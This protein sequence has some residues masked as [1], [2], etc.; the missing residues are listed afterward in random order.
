MS[1]LSR[2][3]RSSTAYRRTARR[4][5]LSLPPTTDATSRPL[6]PELKDKGLGTM[7][8]HFEAS[9]PTGRRPRPRNPACPLLESREPLRGISILSLSFYSNPSNFSAVVQGRKKLFASLCGSLLAHFGPPQ[10]GIRTCPHARRIDRTR[11]PRLSSTCSGPT[12]CLQREANERQSG[13]SI[14]RSL[15]RAC[16]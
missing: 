8:I 14:G 12:P 15:L 4:L 3:Q 2:G 5:P 1:G 10:R 11:Q 7:A 9:P 16:R 13:R 6:L